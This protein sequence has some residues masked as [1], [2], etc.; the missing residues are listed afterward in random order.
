MTEQKERIAGEVELAP[1]G[2]KRQIAGEFAHQV[3]HHQ[4]ADVAFAADHEAILLHQHARAHPGR[5]AG[6]FFDVVLPQETE[7]VEVEFTDEFAHGQSDFDRASDIVKFDVFDLEPAEE[8]PRLGIGFRLRYGAPQIDQVFGLNG[9]HFGAEKALDLGTVEF[10]IVHAAEH[11]ADQTVS[12]GLQPF[13]RAERGDHPGDP[14]ISPRIGDLAGHSAIIELHFAETAGKL[15]DGDQRAVAHGRHVVI[16]RIDVVAG[17]S[18][19]EDHFRPRLHAIDGVHGDEVGQISARDHD[20][21]IDLR[22][23]ESGARGLRPVEGIDHAGIEHPA[24][25]ESRSQTF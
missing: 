15:G 10:Q 14:A 20:Q 18:A 4:S 1:F 3:H 17:L 16:R 19:E 22:V 9:H 12:G 2:L 5:C 7:S 23:A 25:R 6:H 13:D 11:M 21:H 8:P 24:F